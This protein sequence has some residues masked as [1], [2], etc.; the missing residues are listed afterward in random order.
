MKG[1]KVVQDF[2]NQQKVKEQDDGW[3]AG[4]VRR[5]IDV[6]TSYNLASLNGGDTGNYIGEH[7]RG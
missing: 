5:P 2:L 1:F 6:E 3:R 4:N 7:Y